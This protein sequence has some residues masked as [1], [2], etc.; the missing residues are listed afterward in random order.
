[1]QVMNGVI[2]PNGAANQQDPH[3]LLAGW[4]IVI[5]WVVSMNLLIN[6]LASHAASPLEPPTSLDS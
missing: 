5:A 3:L 6:P 2:H 4:M 1:M